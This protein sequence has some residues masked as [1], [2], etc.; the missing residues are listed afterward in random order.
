MPGGW[1]WLASSFTEAPAVLAGSAQGW[2]DDL[3]FAASGLVESMVSAVLAF[4]NLQNSVKFIAI[5]NCQTDLMAGFCCLS[6]PG[7]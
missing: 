4:N 6:E 3:G 5:L 2:A 7:I 1:F